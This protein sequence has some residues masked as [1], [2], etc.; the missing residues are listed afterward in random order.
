VSRWHRGLAA[1]GEIRFERADTD[2]SA[3]RDST[4]A[5][6]LSRVEAAAGGTSRL[7]GRIGRGLLQLEN[8]IWN[9][10]SRSKNP[11]RQEPV[12]R[13]CSRF[14]GAGLGGQADGKIGVEPDGR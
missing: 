2:E 1:R 10:V 12:Y 13:P 7:L 8:V 4:H 14:C 6:V 5:H 9:S 3:S 11:R